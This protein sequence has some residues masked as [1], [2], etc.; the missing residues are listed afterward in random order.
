[1][2]SG[3]NTADLDPRQIWTD[4][5]RDRGI[6]HYLE[7]EE[8]DGHFSS[9]LETR[10]EGVLS[11]PRRV[12]P[13]SDAASDMRIAEAVEDVLD[14]MADFDNTLYE[15]LDALGKGVAIAEIM[16]EFEGR[17]IRPFEQRFRPQG[18]FLFGESTGPQN[19]P[20]RINAVG[21]DALILPENKFVV[22]SFRPHLGNRWGRPLA[23]RRFWPSWF[24]RQDIR[25]WLKFVEKGT[26]TV[27]AK[28]PQGAKEDEKAMALQTAE[29]INDETAV[30]IASNFVIEILEHARQG[31]TDTYQSLAENYANSEISKVVLGQVLTSSGS[32]KGS[33]S[34]ALGQVHNEVRQEKTEVDARS[35]MRVM[36]QQVIRPYVVLNFGPQVNAPR[37]V[38]DYEEGEDL[39]QL[40]ERDERLARIGV[41]LPVSYFHER[42]QLPEAEQD[43][44]VVARRGAD[45]LP[46]SEFAEDDDAADR[47]PGVV[48]GAGV[49]QAR[50]LYA[51]WV[52]GLLDKAAAEVPEDE[53]S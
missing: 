22:H 11:K 15:L 46:P 6:K 29:A 52:A 40:S 25:Q 23:R 37:W 44:P 45:L 36:N 1:M 33:G 4:M 49:R 17:E 39:A 41:P 14:Q 38:I 43:E 35:L 16:Y 32:D 24:K 27:I 2:F 50:G 51:E 30:A 47:E 5:V 48:A 7:M 8:K 20:L 53:E 19:G 18:A 42:Y 13:A 9:Q 3:L 31:K 34:L 26:G 28:Y 10:K 12:I 21:Q